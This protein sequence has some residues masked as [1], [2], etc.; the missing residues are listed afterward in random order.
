VARWRNRGPVAVPDWVF[1]PV[2]AP[3]ADA[4]LDDLQQRDP[5]R[6][7]DVFAELISTPVYLEVP[8]GPVA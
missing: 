4:W 8:G 1:D 7:H 5:E 2:F 3:E 6:W